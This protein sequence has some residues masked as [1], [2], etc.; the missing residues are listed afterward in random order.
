MRRPL[1]LVVLGLTGCISTAPVS[2]STAALG[3]PTGDYPSYDERVVLYGTN[4]ARTDPAKAGWASYP[5]QPPLQ[6]NYA[7][8]E[9]SRAHSVD[10]R[11]KPCFQ[12]N[13]CDGTDC[14]ARIN[15]FYTGSWMSEGENISAGVPDG[16]TA[17]Y[18]WLYEIGAP[19]GET[20]HRDNIFSKD[21]THLGNGFAAGGTA[22][23]NYWTQDFVQTSV[24]RPHLTDGIHVPVKGKTGGAVTFGATY[25][26]ASG[27]AASSVVVIID[28]ACQTLPMARGTAGNATY[29]G[30]ISLADGCHQYYF[31]STTNGVDSTYPDTGSLGVGWGS[32]TCPLFVAGHMAPACGGTGGT[33]GSDAGTGGTGGSDGGTGGTG[34]SDGGTGTGGTGGDDGGIGGVG[35]GGSDPGGGGGGGNPNQ[36]AGGVGCAV[37]GS[38]VPAGLAFAV[39]LLALFLLRSGLK[40]TR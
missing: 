7:L 6:W 37:A 23:T 34:G 15:S 18:N 35:G 40:K 31:R 20:G 21:F 36:G 24:T 1:L 12:H 25:Y 4:R 27:K 9:S 30:P 13:S 32:A 19:A 26:D 8:N 29:E 11:D 2:E 39:L 10:M 16:L 38:D 14:F 33:G 5:A 28:G 3:E 22:F 17:V